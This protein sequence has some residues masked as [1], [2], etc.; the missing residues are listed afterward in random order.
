MATNVSPSI[1][2]DGR[3]IVFFS[4][5][6]LFSIDLFLAETATGRIVRKLV[7]TALSQH[8]TSLQFIGSAGSW[9]PDSRQFVVGGVHAGK[10]VLAILNIANGDVVREIEVPQV[11]EIL[12]PTWSPDGKSIAFSATVGGDS[13]LF[14]YNLESEHDEAGHQ[15]FVC[16]SAARVVAGWRTYRICDRPVHDSGPPRS[17]L[18]ITGWH[19]STSHRGGSSPF[20]PFRRARTSTRSGIRTAADCFSCRIAAGSATSIRSTSSRARWRKS[21]TSTAA[22]AASRR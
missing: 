1:S 6:D 17:R 21:P 4:S 20:P 8:F 11:G 15:R 9:S 10:A 12:N 19:C 5:R 22:S 2:P 3:H 13:D 18:A 7:D 14:I 16:R